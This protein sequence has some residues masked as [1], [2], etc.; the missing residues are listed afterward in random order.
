M[1]DMKQELQYSAKQIVT[2]HYM[3]ERKDPCGTV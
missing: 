3:W 1:I 2:K